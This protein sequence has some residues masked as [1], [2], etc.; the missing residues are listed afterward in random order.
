MIKT[1]NTYY[2]IANDTGHIGPWSPN[3]AK[4]NTAGMTN[5][6]PAVNNFPAAAITYR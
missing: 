3:S 1:G 4:K 5:A 2:L 6:I